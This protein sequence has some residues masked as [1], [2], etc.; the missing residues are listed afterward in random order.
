MVIEKNKHQF[1]IK[2]SKLN[3]ITSFIYLFDKYLL[4]IHYVLLLFQAMKMQW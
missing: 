3:K 2:I 1:H 4:R